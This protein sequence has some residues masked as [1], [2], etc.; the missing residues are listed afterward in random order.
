MKQTLKDSLYAKIE[1]VHPAHS[2]LQSIMQDA[3]VYLFG[4]GVRDY[5]DDTLDISRDLDFVIES[6]SSKLDI[7]KYIVDCECVSYSKNR[8]GGYKIVFANSLVFDVWNLE[9]TWA[10]KTNRL[11]MSAENLME[12]VYLNIDS[13]VYSVTTDTYLKGCDKLYSTMKKERQIDILYDETPFEH[14]NLLRALVLRKKYDMLLS[15]RLKTKFNN[16]YASRG[17]EIIELLLDL[18]LSHYNYPIL[19][20]H[21]LRVELE[22][23][24]QDLSFR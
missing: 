9:D 17:H 15:E 13:L 22:A 14:L 8:F 6:K 12:S 1:N 16:L 20:E 23:V 11:S 7:S 4:G 2:F 21:E 5:L 18:E 10:F 24:K 19:S 3:T